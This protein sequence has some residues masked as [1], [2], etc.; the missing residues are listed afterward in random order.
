MYLLNRDSL[1]GFDQGPGGSDNGR[2]AP[3]AARRRLVAPRGLAG[4]RRLDLHPDLQR[5]D[6]WRP[7]RR[8]QVRPVGHRPA[9]AVAAGQLRP[10]PSAG[11]AARRSSPP[12]AR[13][14]AARSCGSSGR[15]TARA[16]AA[17]S[18][19][20]TRCRSTASRCCAG[21]R[22]SAPRPN[23]STP[24]VGAG[25][26]Y[27]GTRDGKVLGFG[28]PVTPAAERLRPHASRRRRSAT[29]SQ[30]TLTLTANQTL[31]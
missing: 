11:A 5:I 28:S 13:P 20:T 9:F 30:Q 7:A 16:P 25:R 29:R 21:A 22:R 4:R 8:L 10:T 23:Y 24:G 14:P 26:L 3:R 6:R 15:P 17:S 1:G 27:V 19:P 2:P 12:K 18:A 31:T